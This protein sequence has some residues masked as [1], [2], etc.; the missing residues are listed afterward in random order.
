MLKTKILFAPLA[1]IFAGL[2][3]YNCSRAE[4]NNT[5]FVPLIAATPSRSSDLLISEIMD[6]RTDYAGAQ[7]PTYEKYE[8]TFQIEDSIAQNFQFP[9]DP[10]LP[11]GIDPNNPNYQGIT[12]NAIFTPDNW[13]TTYVQPAFYYQEFEDQAL[14]SM[15]WYYPTENF[16][17]KVR[18][19]PD[20]PG[21]WQYKLAAQD[22]SGWVES[23]PQSFSVFASQKPGFVQVSES[24]P[25]YF[26]FENGDY[27]SGLGYNLNYNQVDWINPI[28]GNQ[29]NFQT[30]SENG[31]QLIRI[32]LSQWGI[33]GSAWN[34]WNSPDPGKHAQYI[35]NPGLTYS[36]TYLGNE[37]SMVLAWENEWFSPCMFIG[38]WKAKSAV[39]SD[40]DYRIQIRY[41]V[42]ELGGPRNPDQPSGF[43]AKIGGWLWDSEYCYDPGT[44]TV[45]AATYP[46]GNWKIFSDPSDSS[47]MILEGIFN[48]LNSD[49]L[50]N[51]YLALE[52]MNAGRVN[53]DHVSIEEILIDGEY[54][55]NIVSKPS[56]A[57]HLYFEQRNSYAFDKLLELAATYD[58][59]FRPVIHEKNEWISNTIAADG[60]FTTKSNDN[61][62]GEWR[63]ETKGRW[64]Q[65]AWWR[66]LQARWGYSTQIHSWELLNEGDPANTRHFA[67]ADDLGKFMN[68]QV[69]GVPVDIQNG[70]QCKSTQPNAHIVSTSFWHSFPVENF[71]GNPAYPNIDFAD[72]HAYVS[73]G[74]LKDPLHEKD[75]SAYHIDYGR[76][77][78][79]QL[80]TGSGGDATKPII[81]GE[82]GIDYVNQQN[83]Q[84][85][86]ERDNNGVWLHNMLWA[87]LDGNAMIEEYWWTRNIN[88]QPGPDGIP[89]LHDVFGYFSAFIEDI[90]L[91]NGVYQDVNGVVSNP[92]MQVVGQKDVVNNRAHLWVKNQ[93][94]TWRNVVDGVPGIS[95]LS[96][97]V[98]IEGFSPNTTFSVDWHLFTTIGLPIIS[99]ST[100]T[101]N[102][103]GIIL[104]SLPNDPQI[105]DVGIR[106][107]K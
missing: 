83:E 53:V 5:V 92:R 6:N 100:V 63:Q 86:L 18:F 17:W 49:F 29:A 82:A 57:H 104:L 7:I 81:R 89:G 34:P 68:C 15:S 25:R 87:S 75:A 44:G 50:P 64:L 94:H 74:W 79:T 40:T 103:N 1:I 47:W 4:E 48:T 58:I 96:G 24:D 97:T 9:Y 30:M 31:I 38:A 20:R 95:G 77:V 12:V 67:L 72:V 28:T 66:Y 54:G 19:A 76:N 69:F 85:D 26:E 55:P 102:S 51:F 23:T 56:M 3:L 22:A 14:D 43:V 91:N 2:F 71:W 90:P 70:G 101:T 35:P 46:G 93:D 106:I 11:T 8:I 99:S 105:T 52:N 45:V 78:R 37:L 41:K 88:M 60:S 32:W 80:D 73:T 42:S 107:G 13:E 27:F 36:E 59:Y 84:P 61:F 62:Y 39:K 10:S 65:K 16:S 98:T 33:F 21:I